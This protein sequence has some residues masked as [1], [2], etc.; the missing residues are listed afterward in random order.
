MYAAA[1]LLLATGEARHRESFEAAA[2]PVDEDPSYLNVGGFAARMYLR[3]SAGA[4]ERKAGLLEAMRTRANRARTEGERDPF[5]RSAPRFWGSIGAGFTRTGAS[6]IPLCLQVPGP[7]SPD[8]AQALA[9]VHHALGRNLLQLVYVS[10]LPGVSRG[11]EHAFHHWLAALQAR[12][13]LFP[14][15]VAGGPNEHPEANDVSRPLARPR[16]VWGYL[17]DPAFL[18]DERTP[19]E[20]RY[21]DNDSWSTNEVSLDWQASALYSLAFARWAARSF[22]DGAAAPLPG[23]A[24]GRSR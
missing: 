11:R 20:R 3:A 22:S 4:P 10:G 17:G 23:S 21:T 5:Q 19:Y 9:N 1:G 16:P 8:C 13:F 18:R 2:V 12:P 24:P 6:S 7:D 14:G 15:L